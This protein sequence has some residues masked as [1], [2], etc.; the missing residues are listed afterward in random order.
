MALCGHGQSGPWPELA[1][2]G[3]YIGWAG[4]VLGCPLAVLSMG[5]AGRGLEW[6]WAVLEAECAFHVLAM[7]FK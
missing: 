7:G 4:Y 5:W 2:S 1:M 6:P 3:M